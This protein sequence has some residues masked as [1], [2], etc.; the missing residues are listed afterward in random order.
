[1]TSKTD[2][3]E[4]FFVLDKSLRC[5]YSYRRQ[6]CCKWGHICYAEAPEVWF[7]K[8][9]SELKKLAMIRGQLSFHPQKLRCKGGAVA[10]EMDGNQGGTRMFAK[11]Q[12]VIQ[13]FEQLGSQTLC[14]AG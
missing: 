3:L 1:M 9:E 7:S 8:W 2:E 12:T 10:K 14:D 11:G 4:K 5:G 13:L 6:A